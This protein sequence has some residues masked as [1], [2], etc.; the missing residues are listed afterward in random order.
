MHGNVEYTAKLVSGSIVEPGLQ[1]SLACL[2]GE[3]E[4]GRCVAGSDGPGLV[5]LVD[6][7]AG[8]RDGQRL[9]F[10]NGSSQWGH[11]GRRRTQAANG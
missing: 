10:S 3:S 6:S 1:L 5:E 11:S 9:T 4:H 2:Q 8:L 7:C